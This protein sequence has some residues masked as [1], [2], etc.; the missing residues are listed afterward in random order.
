MQLLYIVVFFACLAT[1]SNSA[2]IKYLTDLTFCGEHT[3]YTEDYHCSVA[4]CV[5][6]EAECSPKWKFR[7]CVC[8][9]GY[10]RDDM[11]Q[12]IRREACKKSKDANGGDF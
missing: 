8:E 2:T 9:D 6:P 7:G 1:L 10:I 5:V 12:C 11:Y 4:S 3:Y